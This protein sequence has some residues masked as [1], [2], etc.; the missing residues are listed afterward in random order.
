MSRC[1]SQETVI[2]INADQV[3][4]RGMECSGT[5]ETPRSSFPG[6]TQRNKHAII[7]IKNAGQSAE[8]QVRWVSRS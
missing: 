7:K 5:N 2:W 3:L 8:V 1:H 4:S 6:N